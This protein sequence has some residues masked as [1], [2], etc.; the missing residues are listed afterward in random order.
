ML[1]NL[2]THKTKRLQQFLPT[3]P[4]T[5]ISR[6]LLIVAESGRDLVLQGRARPDRARHVHLVSDLKR[7]LMRYIRQYNA[8]PNLANQDLPAAN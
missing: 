8:T 4:F 2:S 5:C 7:K 1:D 6:H 3:G